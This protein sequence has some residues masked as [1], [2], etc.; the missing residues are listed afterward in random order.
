[1]TENN[2]QQITEQE[3]HGKTSLD[4]TT[5]K[6]SFVDFSNRYPLF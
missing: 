3:K 4:L 1:M 6:P 5:S 2:N